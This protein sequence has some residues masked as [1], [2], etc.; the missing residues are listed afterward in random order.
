MGRERAAERPQDISG[1]A[2]NAGAGTRP[3]ATQGRS[4][5]R[6]ANRKLCQSAAV[7]NTLTTAQPQ[8]C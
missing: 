3:F 7:I 8:A 6:L 1:D 4:Y 2:E 5:K